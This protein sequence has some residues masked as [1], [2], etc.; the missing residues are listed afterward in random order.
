MAFYPKEDL[1]NNA[2]SVHYRIHRQPMGKVNV[3]I[4]IDTEHSIGGAYR[5]PELKPVGNEKRI[6]GKING[7]EYG[8][9]MMMDIAERY[10]IP[11]SFFVET[12]NQ[13]Y[14]GQSQ[15]RE[16]C[17]YIMKRGHDVQLHLHPTFLNFEEKIPASGKYSDNMC[18]YDLDFQTELI[19]RGKS[20]LT[21]YCGRPPIAFRA[22]NFAANINTLR[23][24]RANG[25]LIDSSYTAH[26][27]AIC[28]DLHN[29]AFGIEGIWEL[30]ITNFVENT[31]LRGKRFKPL[32]LNSVSFAEMRSVLYQSGIGHGPAN[33]T[34]LL[35]SFSFIKAKD[36]Q[37]R[38][39]TV[40]NQAIQRF[41]RICR[42]L[43]NHLETFSPAVHSNTKDFTSANSGEQPAFFSMPPHRSL[44][45]YIQQFVG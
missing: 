26:C 18:A 2:N 28:K 4:T 36:L 31:F 15:T 9:P 11:L 5:D 41:E 29:D 40:N 3:F 33:I 37:Y 13:S 44:L 25:L 34:I 6:F 16:V 20:A 23:A 35:H 8:I 12:L 30:P 45:R 32:D 10:G 17:Q 39:C 42:Y 7:K 21:D 1:P 38:E 27:N 19:R 24:L 43:G 14:F 22:G